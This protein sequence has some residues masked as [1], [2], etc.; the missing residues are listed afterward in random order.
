MK[1]SI[2]ST[3]LA[4]AFI[5]STA[6]CAASPTETG[7]PIL[8][9]SSSAQT[10]ESKPWY[11]SGMPDDYSL[12]ESIISEMPDTE[13]SAVPSETSDI[14]SVPDE[15]Q[16]PDDADMVLISDYI[17]DIALDIRYAT[18]DNFTGQVIY[19][20]ADAYLKYGTVKKLILVQNELKEHGCGL[21]IWDAY[22]PP[23]AQWKLWEVCPDPNYVS[24]P[25][26]GIS[27]HSRGDTVDVTLIDLETKTEL[28]M[29]SAF[30]EFGAAADRDYSDVSLAAAENAKLLEDIMTKHGFS[31]YRKE[32]WHYS[33]KEA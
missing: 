25:N 31:G 20:S 11:S 23:E 30:D 1:K 10:E 4:T 28:L 7:E 2:L 24:D 16:E 19:E 12:S 15:P 22:R 6:S 33:D 3:V 13:S 18:A 5:L 14:I 8:N 26:K 9:G 17:P 32:W 29:P 21:L 27:G